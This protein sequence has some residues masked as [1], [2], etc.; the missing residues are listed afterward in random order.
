MLVATILASALIVQAP[1]PVEGVEVAY[2][3]TVEGRSEAAIRKIEAANEREADHPARLIN[4]GIA[5]ARL[6]NEEKARA[7][8]A[9][10]AGNTERYWL[11]T[12]DG[13]WADAREI[14]QAAMAKLDR[15]EFN[16]PQLATR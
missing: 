9:E 1:V 4:L 7:L 6:G 5:H 12:A 13:R 11:E 16:A 15:G 8:F 2:R 3:E 14:A 10:A